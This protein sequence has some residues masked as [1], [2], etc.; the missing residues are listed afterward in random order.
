[1][2]KFC[3]V[4]SFLLGG[5][6]AFIACG[7]G[8]PELPQINLLEIISGEP[9]LSTFLTALERTSLTT[10]LDSTG[11][12]TVFAP[13]NTAFANFLNTNGYAKV[14]D[15]P[16]SALKQLLLY[17]MVPTVLEE[18]IFIAGSI[19]SLANFGA[20]IIPMQLYLTSKNG[21]G[22]NGVPVAMSEHLANGNLHAVNTVIALP[23]VITPATYDLAFSTFLTA[24]T[25][26][27]LGIDYVA[28][29]SEA[30]PFTLFVPT[31]NAFTA[32]LFELGYAN[33][34]AVPTNALNAILQYHIV[35]NA[36]LTGS[37]LKSLSEVTTLG[38]KKFSITTGTKISDNLG[39]TANL[40]A[41]DFQAV[42]GV[43]HSV[44]KVL[45][46]N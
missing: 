20:P 39:R 8:D 10:M 6:L 11:T 37:D 23:T 26:P 31:N 46:P 21:W 17:H 9:E 40:L 13:T 32:F 42:N 33:L 45:R 25:R 3:F 43:V 2:K 34:D 35:P 16:V 30:G 38:G 15:V 27:D 22:V 7:P 44:D 29:L 12:F 19:P 41:L 18:N 24:L 14:E 28:T 5:S 4:L 36:N 1:M